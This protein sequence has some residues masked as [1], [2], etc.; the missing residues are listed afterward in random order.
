[1]SQQL[2]NDATMGRGPSRAVAKAPGLQLVGWLVWKKKETS[3]NHLVLILSL[4]SQQELRSGG[5]SHFIHIPFLLTTPT[6]LL[7][8]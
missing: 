7:L 8:Q 5:K 1:M 3:S 4:P 2:S 6:I